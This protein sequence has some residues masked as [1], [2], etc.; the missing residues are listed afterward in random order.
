MT[1]R[2]INSLLPIATLG[3]LSAV[4]S[5]NT[6]TATFFASHDGEYMLMRSLVAARAF[7]FREFPIHW[8]QSLNHY[9]GVPVFKYFYPLWHWIAAG[10]SVLLN[11]PL[12]SVVTTLYALTFFVSSLGMYGWLRSER[13]T[14]WASFAG[15]ALY[16]LAPYR[17]L[18]VY[19]RGS[20]ESFGYAL[21]PVLLWSF[22][23]Y[24][25]NH[26]SNFRLL[27]ASLMF[28]A[29]SLS[30]NVVVFLALPII[31]GYCIAQSLR[32]RKWV[33]TGK[34]GLCSLL[35]SGFFWFPSLLNQ[36]LTRLVDQKA[37]IEGNLLSVRQLIYSP[38]G[39]TYQ[40]G[41]IKGSTPS[42]ISFSIGLAQLIGVGISIVVALII[43]QN[44]REK[45]LR[46][47]AI[48]LLF[49][50]YFYLATIYSVPVWTAL[51]HLDVIQFPFRL[52]GPLVFLAS[53]LSALAISSLKNQRGQ[54]LLTLCLVLLAGYSIRNYLRPNPVQ[55]VSIFSTLE[56]HP[57]RLSSTGISD[58]ILSRNDAHACTSDEAI[59]S[60]PAVS[61]IR[62]ETT[63]RTGTI[64]FYSPQ[65]VT[66]DFQVALSYF[67]EIY[68]FQLNGVPVSY[69]EQSG[70][71]V[72][73][74]ATIHEGENLLTWRI[75]MSR[76]ERIS[77]L[78]SVFTFGMLLCGL[79]MQGITRLSKTGVL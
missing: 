64:S 51:P 70:R 10:A 17:M 55:D 32:S 65:T 43:I 62:R 11:L 57:L 75:Q 69:S 38:W 50:G 53:L 31:A 52:I 30:H 67:P 16:L 6:K 34:L 78:L 40:A 1:L 66:S 39:Y 59:V 24:Y 35:L 45:G 28:C 21:L 4:C 72:L 79:G 19:V 25:K 77:L 71:V 36:S 9:C 54:F 7:S 74:S 12:V 5:Y 23:L 46:L 42:G 26:Q 15:A 61:N 44:S 13:L 29:F 18:N 22:S 41:S 37:V 60:L 48:L 76:I 2:R 20:V 58:E 8:S 49:L 68:S 14:V 73:S 27:L 56:N 3:I 63:E 33:S 47:I